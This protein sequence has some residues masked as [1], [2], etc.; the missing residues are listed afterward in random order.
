MIR[1]SLAGEFMAFIVLITLMLY[2]H[3]KRVVISARK[4]SMVYVYYFLSF[5]LD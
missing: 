4:D 1:W 3:E 5:V 2:F